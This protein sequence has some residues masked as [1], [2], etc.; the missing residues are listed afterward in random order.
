M[1]WDQSPF[2]K[3]ERREIAH[4]QGRIGTYPEAPFVYIEAWDGDTDRMTGCMDFDL[5]EAIQLRDFLNEALPPR[6]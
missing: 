1:K 5:E 2:R 4:G 3:L 6:E